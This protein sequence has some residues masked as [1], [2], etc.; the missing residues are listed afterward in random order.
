MQI[1]YILILTPWVEKAFLIYGLQTN[2][3]NLIQMVK[4]MGQTQGAEMSPDRVSSIYITHITLF[5]QE[6]LQ[7]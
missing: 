3:R 5:K 2:L 1:V 4:N 6:F 7:F